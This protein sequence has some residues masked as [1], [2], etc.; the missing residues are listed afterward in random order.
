M[1]FTNKVYNGAKFVALVLLPALGTLYFGLAD[2]WHFPDPEKVVGSITVLDT[3][4]GVVL[5]IST[6]TYNNSDDKYAGKF[7]VLQNPDGSQYLKL[8]SIDP[9]VLN[10]SSK[11]ELTFRVQP[12]VTTAEPATPPAT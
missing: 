1:R 4:L 9:D 7:A 12:G 10:N 6:K 5:H 2:L 8:I 11:T 3:F